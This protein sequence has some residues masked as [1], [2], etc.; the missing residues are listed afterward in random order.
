LDCEA[1]IRLLGQVGMLCLELVELGAQS[2]DLDHHRRALLLDEAS[3]WEHLDTNGF[4]V[5]CSTGSD[6]P[7]GL[8]G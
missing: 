2:R 8:A 3:G 6:V 1:T 4:G 7:L 5:K